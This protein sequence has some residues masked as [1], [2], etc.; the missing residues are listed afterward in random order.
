MRQYLDLLEHVLDNGG[1]KKEDR[2][3]T[4]YPEHLWLPDAF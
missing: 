2:T 4:G 1:V 3:G